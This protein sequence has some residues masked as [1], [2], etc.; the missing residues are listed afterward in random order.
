MMTRIAAI[1]RFLIFISVALLAGVV[2]LPGAG[3]Q[4]WQTV[5]WVDDGDTIVLDNR[6][7]IRYIGINAPEVAHKDQPTEPYGAAAKKYNITLVYRKQI[8][9][10]Y[11]TDRKDRH[12][13]VLAYVFL[14]DGRFVNELVLRQG[15]AF[16]LYDK[17]NHRYDDLFLKIQQ[18]A[19]R[20]GKGIWHAWRGSK[21]EYLGN[22]TSRRFHLKNC[23]FGKKTARKNRVYFKTKWDA[24]WAG[25]APAKGCLREYWKD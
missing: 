12:G 15:Y 21:T 23:P 1:Y 11:D 16:L 19:M 9:L 8:R 24:F 25:F 14:R 17:L 2:R 4:E 6:S 13:R 3:A 7:R 10:E 20:S 22:R 5:R 18:E